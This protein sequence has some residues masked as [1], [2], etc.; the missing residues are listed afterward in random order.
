MNENEINSLIKKTIGKLKYPFL[1]V[2]VKITKLLFYDDNDIGSLSFSSST[3]NTLVYKNKNIYEIDC[4]YS[5]RSYLT[6]TYK[7]KNIIEDKVTDT[8]QLSLSGL[9]KIEKEDIKI[10]FTVKPNMVYYPPNSVFG[11]Y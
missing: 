7:D 3:T 2:N 1:S 5:Q 6:L 10:R 8:I 11:G 4:Q 9:L